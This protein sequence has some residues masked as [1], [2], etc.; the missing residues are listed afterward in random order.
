MLANDEIRLDLLRRDPAWILR[1]E[2]SLGC[3]AALFVVVTNRC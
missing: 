3:D 2:M 1:L